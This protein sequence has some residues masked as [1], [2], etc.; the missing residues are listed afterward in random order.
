[1]AKIR[2]QELAK[3]LN[4]S[5]Q[6]IMKKLEGA[7]HFRAESHEHADAGRGGAGK[8]VRSP[9]KKIVVKKKTVT[10]APEAAAEKYGGN[11]SA[12]GSQEGRSAGPGQDRAGS[13]EEGGAG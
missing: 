6:D 11:A 13:G 8:V 9:G 3:E 7:G 10:P 1:M 4:V 5:T 2:V 12:D